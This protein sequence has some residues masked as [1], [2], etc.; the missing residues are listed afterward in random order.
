[1]E[2]FVLPSLKMQLHIRPAEISDLLLLRALSIESFVKAY[3]SFNTEADMRNYLSDNFSE[4]KLQQELSDNSLLYL[5]AFSDEELTGYVKLNL[6]PG[7]KGGANNPVEIARLYSHPDRIGKGIGKQI[8]DA[9]V[10]YAR[11]KKH[12]AIVL[13]VWQKN[14]RA[15]NFY[16]REGFSI[17][18]LTQFQLGNDVQD[19]FVMIKHMTT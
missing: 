18:G 6:Y 5:L 15:V 2:D 10:D 19:D 3:A 9:V 4:E 16:Q 17:C 11:S 12:D 13:D 8:L 14:F 7:T 1:M